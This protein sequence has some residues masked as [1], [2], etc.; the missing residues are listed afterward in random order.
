MIKTQKKKQGHR[1]LE[2]M[3]SMGV[4]RD[5]GEGSVHACRLL[6]YIYARSSEG[7]CCNVS[8]ITKSLIWRCDSSEMAGDQ[9]SIRL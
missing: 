9:R 7:V 2:G 4:L 3:L 1:L 8:A 6:R 5:G